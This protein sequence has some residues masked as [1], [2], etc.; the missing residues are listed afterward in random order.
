MKNLSCRSKA[1][2]EHSTRFNLKITHKQCSKFRFRGKRWKNF[3]E[4]GRKLHK[5]RV[6]YKAF[7]L[8]YELK[9]SPTLR[10][11]IRRGKNEVGGVGND[12]NAQYIPLYIYQSYSKLLISQLCNLKVFYLVGSRSWAGLFF[13]RGSD[14]VF[15]AGSGSTT[16]GSATLAASVS[17]WKQSF[18][19]G[20][21]A[22]LITCNIIF[23]FLGRYQT[24]FYIIVQN[25][26]VYIKV[27]GTKK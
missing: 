15:L 19:E 18:E 3:K 20:S 11:F 16:P 7:L 5:K 27:Q 22:R 8:G 24:K 21:L 6:T 13:F 2:L 25:C 26:F 23:L 9:N 12:I 10:N 1:R 4:K 14:P 17:L